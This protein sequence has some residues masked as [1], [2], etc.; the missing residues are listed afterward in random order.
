MTDF[1]IADND[2]KAKEI[3][4]A[5]LTQ[6]GNFRIDI[7]KQEN[8]IRITKLDSGKEYNILTEKLIEL[9]DALSKEQNGVLYRSVLDIIEKPLIKHAL[10]RAEG[11]QLKAS[12]ILGINRNTMRAKIKKLGI[13]TQEYKV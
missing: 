10:E 2:E 6:Q 3:L 5:M 12:R 7:A 1:L 8:T 11:N 13:N 9:G 4:L